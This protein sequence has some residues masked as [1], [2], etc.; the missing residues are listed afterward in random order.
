MLTSLSKNGEKSFVKK[1]IVGLL[2]GIVITLCV[3]LIQYNTPLFKSKV[4]LLA[5][6]PPVGETLDSKVTG[7]Y[8]MSLSR[9]RFKVKN[10]GFKP[11]HL[12]KV[13][14]LPYEHRPIPKIELISLNSGDIAPFKT[15]WA[16]VILRVFIEHGSDK[17]KAYTLEFYDEYG[18]YAGRLESHLVKVPQGEDPNEY[19]K[20]LH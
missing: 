19:I 16:N 5:D 18:D 11:G 17:Q 12:A 8:D 6:E 13:V 15:K 3:L 7:T 14:I 1:F 2:S 20:Q 4:R 9:W 10:S